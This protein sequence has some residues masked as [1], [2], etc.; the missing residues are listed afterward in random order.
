MKS[1]TRKVTRRALS[2]SDDDSDNIDAGVKRIVRERNV[3]ERQGMQEAPAA[4]EVPRRP[5]SPGLGF[6]P[7]KTSGGRLP[8]R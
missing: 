5:L 6:R 2:P 4:K 3:Q 7:S 1:G 8:H